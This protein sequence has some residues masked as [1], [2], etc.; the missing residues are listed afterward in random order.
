MDGPTDNLWIHGGP[1]TGK[2]VLA[3][4]LIDFVQERIAK[5][6]KNTTTQSS[7]SE[8]LLY[9]FCDG[10]SAANLKASSNSIALTLL[11][12]LVNNPDLQLENFPV[13]VE[14]VTFASTNFNFPVG[15]LVEHLM[16]MLGTFSKAW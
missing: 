10:R 12:Q 13:F 4:Y 15:K 11:T 9:F 3:A 6:K 7:S 1:G 16:V 5:S 14:Y 8:V 2:S